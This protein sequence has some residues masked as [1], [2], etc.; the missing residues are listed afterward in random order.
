MSLLTSVIEF[1]LT[2]PA[3]VWLVLILGSSVVTGGVVISLVKTEML[4]ILL[5]GLRSLH[6][7]GL[8]GLVQELGVM[9]IGPCYH[10]AQGPTLCLHKKAPFCAGLPTVCG[11]GA[12]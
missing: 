8:K 9:D 2:Y 1:L 11:I 6:H 10:D 12:N 7:D 3:D 5:R 4:G